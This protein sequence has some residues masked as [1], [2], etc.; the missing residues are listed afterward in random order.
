[1]D[2]ILKVLEG[3]KT[4]T[5]IAVK[6]NEFLV[7]RSQECHLC[8]GSSSV[9]RRHC[10]I[11]RKDAVV[12]IRDLGS[13]NGTVVN[14]KKTSGEVELSSGDEIGIGT[15]KLLLTI[16]HGINNL[17]RPKVKSVAEAVERTVATGDSTVGEDDITK[18]LHDAPGPPPSSQVM[19]ETQTIRMDDTNAM[20]LREQVEKQ[21]A[22]Q[23]Q[24]D[25]ASAEETDEEDDSKGKKKKK[26]PG[27]LP[28]VPNEPASKDSREA[29]MMALRNWN[30]RR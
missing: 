6:K 1:M 13:R 12:S 16:T 23:Q 25:E 2:V 15:L 11:T 27:K 9:S 3:A 4:G 8:A 22:D 19:S 28:P 7:G 26:E 17:K 20:Q 29:A 10:V 21:Q 30:R 24:P 5:K 14:G 18:W